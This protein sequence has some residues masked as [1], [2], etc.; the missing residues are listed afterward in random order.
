MNFIYPSNIL[1]VKLFSY[2]YFLILF[3]LIIPLLYGFSS[4]GS[5][6]FSPSDL[7]DSHPSDSSSS[8]DN[9]SSDVR[10]SSSD[11]DFTVPVTT[12]FDNSYSEIKTS[13]TASEFRAVKCARVTKPKFKELHLPGVTI[14]TVTLNRAS[15][16]V[17][18]MDA[19]LYSKCLAMT[20]EDYKI[21]NYDEKIKMI[22]DEAKK[23]VEWAVQKIK[24][25]RRATSQKVYEDVLSIA[26]LEIQAF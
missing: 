25:L 16:L 13:T 6:S 3:C 8:S 20:S 18:Q 14:S 23:E 10:S 26:E 2:I 24:L 4:S 21:P 17:K 9:G 1:L 12:P 19:I 11:F 22:G 5:G 15:T 7:L